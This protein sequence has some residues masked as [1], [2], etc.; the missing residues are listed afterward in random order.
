M[1]QTMKTRIG[2]LYERNVKTMELNAA[3]FLHMFSQTQ[4]HAKRMKSD[5][6]LAHRCSVVE[7]EHSEPRH[8]HIGCGV[9]AFF[10]HWAKL[11][12]LVDVWFDS[13]GGAR[14]VTGTLKPCFVK[15]LAAIAEIARKTATPYIVVQH[16][17]RDE[18]SRVA[19]D[20]SKPDGEP[21]D[22]YQPYA[23][24]NEFGVVERWIL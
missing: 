22:L 23:F 6:V 18:L 9:D 1:E 24:V 4:K 3:G 20:E 19:Y 13:K 15:Q 8:S 10:S 2:T 17:L 21:N 11:G 14:T 12:G 5:R 16:L 7:V